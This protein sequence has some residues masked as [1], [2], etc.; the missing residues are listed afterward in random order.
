[1]R[2]T[3]S[4]TARWWSARRGR[5]TS[6]TRSSTRPWTRSSPREGVTGWADTW[7][8]SANAPHPNCMLKWMDWTMQPDVQAEVAVYYGAAGSNV[9]V[10][11]RDPLLPH[12]R[13]RRGLP[14][15]P[16]TPLRYSYCGDEEF[17]NSLYLWK[18]PSVD[19]GDDRG[20]GLHRL[21]GVD[22]GLDGD[23]R[24]GRAGS[25]D[26]RAPGDEPIPRG[27]RSAEATMAAVATARRRAGAVRRTSA[28]LFRHP[29]AKLSLSLGAPL[30]WFLRRLPRFARSCS[31]RPRSGIST[32]SRPRSCGASSLT[33]FET[34]LSRRRLP[35]DHAPDGRDRGGGHHHRHRPVVPARVLRRPAGHAADAQRAADRGRA[36]AV[37]ELPGPGVRVEDHPHAERVPELAGR[38]S[39]GSARCSS[40]RSNWA[41]WITFVYL[42]LPFTLLPIYAA[43]ER[44][45]DS[46]L[47]ASGGS[48]RSWVDHV[49]QRDVPADPAGDRCRI[50]LRVLA[51]A[52]A[53]TSPPSSSG[54]HSSSGT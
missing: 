5:S 27:S 49:P 42:W 35:D 29:R 36:A 34:L 18:T 25:I 3:G 23:R 19:C 24:L 26:R 39:P 12:R 4:S 48:R 41:V 20:R 7:M 37:G 44:V 28:F 38:G 47:E 17:L 10:V 33:N 40:G 31:S 51:H 2:S 30:A 46:F 54:T 14:T 8:I 9:G 6:R 13:L 52:R 1:M 43:L 15:R 32:S 22:A 21:L 53:T 11:R 45:P 16:W 50:D